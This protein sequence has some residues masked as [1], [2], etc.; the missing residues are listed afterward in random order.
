M[1]DLAIRIENLSKCYRI[2]P[3]ECNVGNR[4]TDTATASRA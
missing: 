1:T 4:E 2:S 3:R